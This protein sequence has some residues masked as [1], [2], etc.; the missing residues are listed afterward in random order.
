MNL[1]KVYGCNYKATHK[2]NKHNCSNCG[3]I[4]HGKVECGNS[5]AINFLKE[6]YDYDKF[7]S[8]EKY[9]NDNDI[10][11][12][13]AKLNDGE[14][15]F[16]CLELGS[17]LFIRKIYKNRYQFLFMDQDDWGQYDIGISTSRKLKYDN[18]IFLYKKIII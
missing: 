16:I 6:Y 15:T 5:L 7:S 14:Y 10:K 2:S 17:Q 8:I 13:K 4:G 3:I 9:I 11:I 1:C 18:F 12:I